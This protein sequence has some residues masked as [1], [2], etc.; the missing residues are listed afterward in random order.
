MRS[1]ELKCLSPQVLP[2]NTKGV[3]ANA[4]DDDDDGDAADRSLE[5]KRRQ[6]QGSAASEGVLE[7][8]LGA[9]DLDAEHMKV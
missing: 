9:E 2:N 4:V 3:V 5:Q 7:P 8:L 1:G 6:Q